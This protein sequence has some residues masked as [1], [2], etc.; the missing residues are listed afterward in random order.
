MLFPQDSTALGLL[1]EVSRSHSDTPHSVG[2][3]WTSDQPDTQRPLPENIQHLKEERD[4]RALGRIRTHNPS[5][6]AAVDP[7]RIKVDTV[8][9]CQ[10]SCSPATNFVI[11]SGL[12]LFMAS[13]FR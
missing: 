12:Q 3:P 5:K 4:I 13:W 8:E 1:Y 6:G 10:Y 9:I 7:L 2:L 11:L